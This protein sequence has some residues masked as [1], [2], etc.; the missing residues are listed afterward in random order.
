MIVYQ[1]RLVT[2][3][4]SMAYWMFPESVRRSERN[5]RERTD[6]SWAHQQVFFRIPSSPF[7]VRSPRPRTVGFLPRT[8]QEQA[9]CLRGTKPT[10]CQKPQVVR[11][12]E[13][14]PATAS[15]SDR[16][17]FN[18]REAVK[19]GDCQSPE[20]DVSSQLKEL[21]EQSETSRT[22][23]FE[24]RFRRICPE[25]ENSRRT[26]ELAN[27]FPEGGRRT[28]NAFGPPIRGSEETGK[29]LS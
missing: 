10:P 12:P 27:D 8:W 21:T 18:C 17:Q 9:H 3:S 19:L 2:G 29:D 7:L 16:R 28:W 13:R 20:K 15:E 5:R 26:V 25:W 23:Q 22:R 14:L 11:V 4:P 24:R 1:Y 6:Q